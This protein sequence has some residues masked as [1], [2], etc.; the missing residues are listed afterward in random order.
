MIWHSSEFETLLRVIFGPS[1]SEASIDGLAAAQR[2]F[3]RLSMW[4]SYIAD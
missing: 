4:Y 1:T 2:I 3:I